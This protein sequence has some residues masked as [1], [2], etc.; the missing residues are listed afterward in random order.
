MPENASLVIPDSVKTIGMEAFKNCSKLNTVELPLALV[1]IGDKAF[2]NCSKLSLIVCASET[3]ATIFENTFPVHAITIGVPQG[4]KDAYMNAPYWGNENYS[5]FDSMSSISE[6]DE[7]EEVPGIYQVLTD[8]NNMATS[9]AIVDDVEVIG[10]FAIPETVVHNGVEYP[11]TA[12]APSTF[13]KNI[14]LTSVTIPSSID[15][16]GEYA[17]AGCSN[18]KSITVNWSEPIDLATPAS[19]RGLQTRSDGNTVFEGVDK[20]TCILYVPNG[21]VD[22]Y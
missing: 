21:S 8:D 10:D 2:E 20:A 11:V 17:F 6:G 9:V 19:V 18:L 12:I 15:F 4:T 1:S 22:D 7:T 5:F 16:I 14:G 13:E 3:P